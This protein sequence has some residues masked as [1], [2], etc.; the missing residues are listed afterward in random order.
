MGRKHCGKWRNCLLWAIFPFPSVFKRLVLQTHKNQ[1][2]FWKGLKYKVPKH[3]HLAMFWNFSVGWCH[4]VNIRTVQS[5]MSR[6]LISHMFETR[7]FIMAIL[8]WKQGL[9]CDKRF[10]F[11]T[12]W[13]HRFT[14]K[15][16][17]DSVVKVPIAPNYK[18]VCL[19]NTSKPHSYH[20]KIWWLLWLYG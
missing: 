11:Q 17:S 1:G 7:K 15:R 12:F 9:L 14:Y 2:L 4:D 5:M 20:L 10:S 6:N 3:F 13:T 16:Y 18:G 8:H 19:Q